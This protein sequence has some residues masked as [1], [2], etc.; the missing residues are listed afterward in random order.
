M[1][2][3]KETNREFCSRMVVEFTGTF[4]TDGQILFCNFCESSLVGASK[5]SHVKQHI[6][7]VKHKINIQGKMKQ[8]PYKYCPTTSADVERSFSMNKCVLTEKRRHFLFENLKH[9]CIVL[10][11]REK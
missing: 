1:G 11:N 7:S 2:K 3:V 4:R 6:G 9:H 10:C 8:A 5:I